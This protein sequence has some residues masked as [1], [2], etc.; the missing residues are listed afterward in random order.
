M[1]Y[2]IAKFALI[3]L[4][5]TIAGFILGRWMTRRTFVDVTESYEDFRVIAGQADPSQWDKLWHHFDVIASPQEANMDSVNRRLDALA[6]AITNLPKPQSLNLA[7]VESRLDAVDRTVGGLS[8]RDDISPIGN[9]LG[10]IESR[11]EELAELQ[12]KTPDSTEIP[13]E[14]SNAETAV[15]KEA[16]F[17]EKDD[18]KRI[19]GIGGKLEQLLN[20]TGIYYFWQ[21]ATWTQHDIEYIDQRLDTFKGRIVRDG[22]ISQANRLRSAPKAAQQPT[23]MR[24]SA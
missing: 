4:L 18:L 21:I 12:A 2:L 24:I 11:L 22:W 6:Y 5:A 7:E 1:T 17:G 19:S 23:E 10:A 8:T 15:L 16:V 3:F 9:R 20:D 13:A 14:S